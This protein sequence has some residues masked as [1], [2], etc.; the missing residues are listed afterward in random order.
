[1][2]LGDSLTAGRGD[3][4][5]DGLR[6]GW[7]RRLAQILTDRTAERCE[8]TNLAMDGA[9]AAAVL[10]QQLPRLAAARPDLVSL[11][12]GMNDVRVAGF[13][14]DTFASVVGRLFDGMKATGATIMTCTLPD[15]SATVPLPPEHVAIARVRLRLASEIIRETAASAGAV[16]L[17]MWGMHAAVGDAEL[18]TADRLHPNSL[19][20]SAIAAAFADLLIDRG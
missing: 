5:P 7:P 2:A 12:V 19:G 15:V 6:V 8:L 18:F 20:H 14:E 13:S 17:D 11:T 3:I 4:G 16:C 1:V 9:D 10:G